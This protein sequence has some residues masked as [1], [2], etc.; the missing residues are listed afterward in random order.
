MNRLIVAG[1]SLAIL[2]GGW[3]IQPSGTSASFRGLSVVDAQTVWVSGSRGTF[4]RTT[5][6][7]TTWKLDSIAGAESLDLRDLQAFDASIAVA[8]SAGPAEK[9]QAK[10]FRTTDGGATWTTVFTTDQKGVFFDAVSF[11]DARHGIVL[12]DPVDGKLFLLVT[13]DGGADRLTPGLRRAE[14]RSRGSFAPRIADGAGPSPRRRCIPGT[15]VR[16]GSSRW[17]SPTRPRASSSVVT[18]TNRG[19]PP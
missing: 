1:L 14:P 19:R 15:A 18:T 6:G 9:G 10:V 17:P 12:S 4:L 2:S 5:N 16:P 7:G 11:W 3:I 8:I 13:D